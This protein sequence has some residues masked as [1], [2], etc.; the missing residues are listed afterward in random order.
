M[1]VAYSSMQGEL[2]DSRARCKELEEEKQNMRLQLNATEIEIEEL[3][4]EMKNAEERHFHILMRV[5]SERDLLHERLSQ[6]QDN[7]GLKLQPYMT[8]ERNS[9]TVQE[10]IARGGWGAVSKGKVHGNPVAIKQPHKVI[11]HQSLIDRMKREVSCMARVHHPNIVTFIGAVFDGCPAPMII[12]EL[13]DMNLRSAYEGIDFTRN[14]MIDIFQDIAYALHYL[15]ELKIPIIHRDLS[16]P[17]VLLNSFP[18][19]QGF[20]A[21][22]TDFGS[23]NLEKVSQ[24]SG[25]GALIYSAPEMFPPTDPRQHL[26]KQTVKIDSFSYGM[27]LCEVIERK[28]PLV[29]DRWKML[30]AVERR[31]NNI[32]GL[33]MSCIEPEPLNRPNMAEILKSLRNNNTVSAV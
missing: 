30:Q 11:L 22:V 12:T 14:Q 20:I 27:V 4:K 18:Q 16:A 13:M 3:T 21:K 5:E 2:L 25:E 24:T 33:I 15:H 9:V 32:H 28:L 29:E 7:P 19:S 23:A 8:L 6:L 31:W 1:H 10:E 17:N 26:P